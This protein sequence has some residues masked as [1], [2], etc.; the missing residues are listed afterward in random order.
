MS[1]S[2]RTRD[3]SVGGTLLVAA[4]NA[5]AEHKRAANYVCDG[6]ADDVEIQAAVDA[7]PS[8]G[9]MVVLSE[10]T[11]SLDAQISKAG[12]NVCIAGAGPATR[13][14]LDGST[15]VI[16][17]AAQNRWLLINFET[18]AG[19][20]NIGTGSGSVARVWDNSVYTEA[21]ST[22]DLTAPLSVIADPADGNAIPVTASGYC[23]LV[24]SGAETRTLAAPTFIG[25]RLLLYFKTDGGDCVVTCSTTINES[26]SNTLTFANT[27]EMIELVAVEEGS[28]IRWRDI[29][30]VSRETQAFRIPLVTVLGADGLDLTASETAGDFYRSIGTNQLLLLG[31]ISNGTSEADR[32][33]SVGLFEFQLPGNY[34]PGSPITIRAGV[35]VTGSGSIES[36]TIDFSAYLQDGVAGTVGSDIVSTSAAA[37][38]ATAA[39]KDF[40]VTPTSRVAGELLTI[41]MTTSVSNAD[42]TPIQAQISALEVRCDVYAPVGISTP[43]IATV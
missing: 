16:T 30:G 39:N 26:G 23:A 8:S 42:S 29:T 9:G 11:F 27:G 20:V 21:V 34:I 4:H 17:A 1:K 43:V 7:L 10:G 32:E 5:T 2:Q 24:S 14:N 3:D 15:A 35:D 37:I 31:E 6:R 36:S 40:V 13:L 41:K 33:V 38:T 22:V 18:D 12:D 19:G 28:N 25:Q